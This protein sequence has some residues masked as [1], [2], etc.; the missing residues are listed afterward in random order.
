MEDERRLSKA[1]VD[2]LCTLRLNDAPLNLHS[3]FCS[4]HSM[5]YTLYPVRSHLA[6]AFPLT[7]ANRLDEPHN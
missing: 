5:P 6:P 3:A 7:R 4:R 2:R 1:E